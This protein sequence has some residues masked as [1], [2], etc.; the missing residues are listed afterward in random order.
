MEKTYA[1]KLLEYVKYMLQVKRGT[2]VKFPF[3]YCCDNSCGLAFSNYQVRNY[4]QCKEHPGCAKYRK[5]TFWDWLFDI[6][7]PETLS[8]V[9]HS[10]VC[11]AY[12]EVKCSECSLKFRGAYR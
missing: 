3:G 6:D 12:H 8:S 7:R 9:Y 5:K 2:R 11:Q 1:Q 4:H 10:C